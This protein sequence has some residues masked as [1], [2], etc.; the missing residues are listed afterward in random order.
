MLSI[1]GLGDTASSPYKCNSTICYGADGGATH[2][3]FKELQFQLNR[4]GVAQLGNRWVPIK[5]DGFIGAGTVGAVRFV[6]PLVQGLAQYAN[7]PTFETL[8]KWISEQAW[9][10]GV[11]HTTADA[12]RPAAVEAPAKTAARVAAYAAEGSAKTSVPPPPNV[13]APKPDVYVPGTSTPTAPASAYGPPYTPPEK[14]GGAIVWGVAVVAAVGLI[15]AAAY[16]MKR[17]KRR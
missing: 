11:L 17:R 10:V 9:I 13:T 12:L 6:F 14:K 3:L 4:V 16:A 5:V 2:A 1:A 8:S 15:G 7:P